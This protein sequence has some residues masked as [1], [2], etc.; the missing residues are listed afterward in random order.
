MV[1]REKSYHQYSHCD[2]RYARIKCL[3]FIVEAINEQEKKKSRKLKVI[4]IGCGN[5]DIALPIASLGHQVLGTDVDPPSIQVARRENIFPN[6]RFFVCDGEEL[7]VKEKFD[8]IIATEVLEH[9]TEPFKLLAGCK[10]LMES[11]GLLILTVP[12]GYGPFE[13]GVNGL[14]L[15]GKVLRGLQLRRLLESIKTTFFAG[16]KRN[17]R[18]SSNPDSYHVQH[19]TLERVQSLLARSGFQIVTLGH[20]DFLTPVLELPL[21]FKVP[22][23]LHYLDWWL[24]DRLPHPM[25]SGWYF[26]CRAA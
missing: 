4:E 11:D 16:A 22:D 24:A 23:R 21:R 5:G 8:V 3:D 6:A 13:L 19:F 7:S 25:V 2:T 15:A 14:I 12:N 17:A 1:M 9:V 10:E 20:S 26:L 18:Y